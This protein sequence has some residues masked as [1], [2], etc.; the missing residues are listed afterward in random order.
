M[1]DYIEWVIVSRVSD[2]KLGIY[3]FNLENLVPLS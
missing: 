2:I 3:A 1:K